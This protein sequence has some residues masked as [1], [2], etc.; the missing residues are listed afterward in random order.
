MAL[1]SV[2]PTDPFLIALAE[3]LVAG[4]FWPAGPPRDDP[5]A[6]ARVTVYLPTRRAARSLADAI[7]EVAPGGATVLP[8]VEALGEVDGDDD[9]PSM[10]ARLALA[11]LVKA[12]AARSS[13]VQ[14]DQ[15]ETIVLAPGV[16]ADAVRLAGELLALL[17]QVAAQELSWDALPG[18]VEEAELAEHW[19][20]ILGFLTIATEG[21]PAIA[22]EHGFTLTADRRRARAAGAIERLA[23]HTDGPVIAAGSTGSLPATRRL[24]AA[25]HQ[26]PM[27]HVVLPGFDRA[28]SAADWDALAA[29]ED[30]PAHAQFGLSQLLAALEARPQDV[31]RLGPRSAGVVQRDLFDGLSSPEHTRAVPD[32]M[33]PFAPE[34][35]PAFQRSGHFA[36]AAYGAKCPRAVPDRMEP[37]APEKPP[38][39]QRSGHFAR[40]ADGAKCPSRTELWRMALRPAQQTHLWPDDRAA[41]ADLGSAC[42]GLTL[43]NA[44]DDRTEAAAIALALRNA[45]DDGATAAL[46][47]PD[48][49]LARRVGHALV[50]LGV[51]AD[52]SAGEALAVTPAGV[53][54]RLLARVAAGA[55]AADWLA[56]IKHPLITFQ[57]ADREG[58]IRAAEHALRGPRM[59]PDAVL[60]Q[61]VTAMADHP[62]ADAMAAALGPFQ[63][64][65]RAA[66]EVATTDLAGAHLAA[67]D[68]AVADR[69]RA[70]C[71]AVRDVLG[72]IARVLPLATNPADWAETFVSLSDGEVLRGPA[73]MAAVQILGPLEARLQSFDRVVLGG[74]NEGVWPAATDTGP[75]MS[76]PMMSAFGLDLPERRTG[77]A[78][79]DIYTLAGHRQVTLTRAARSAGAAMLPSRWWQRLEVFAGDALEGAVA[80]GNTLLA[81]AAALE[82]LEPVQ[83]AARPCPAPP[84]DV[85]PTRFSVTEVA[86]LIRDPYAVYAKRILGLTPLDPLEEITDGGDRGTLFHAVLATFS[87][88]VAPDG[89]DA[90]GVW[91]AASQS[92]LERFAH[93]P[94]AQAVWRQR[95]ELVGP[96]AI[97]EFRAGM[98][99]VTNRLAEVSAEAEVWQEYTLRGRIDRVD[100]L[101]DG[102]VAVIDYKTSAKPPTPNQVATLM[103]PQLP[104]EAGLL[105]LGAL[106]D[107]PRHTPIAELA[108]VQLGQPG[109]PFKRSNVTSDAGGAQQGAEALA[110]LRALLAFYAEPGNGYLARARMQLESVVSDY[111]HLSRADEWRA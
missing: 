12:W 110:R 82:R 67:F 27:G 102:T 55:G 43:V 30:A 53:S 83:P 28:A 45:V 89:S 108:Y 18:L 100:V 90:E 35:P 4:T 22:R 52:D 25:I 31:Q 95:L 49:N 41:F 78:A 37:F 11:T 61:L 65:C 40:A 10:G 85:R 111:D 99:S 57:V 20:L 29:A 93:A 9:A 79:H 73:E 23:E 68:A 38:A 14:E 103:E 91:Q 87:N 76:R 8:R 39:F 88:E 81:Q 48:R 105:G 72:V 5:F 104:L 62:L 54:A 96:A 66:A 24:I 33:E 75:W 101:A 97:A 70:D 15:D 98:G 47:T 56:L 7:L 84:V 34:K 21:W 3:H 42:E 44:E 59:A 51:K 106:A 50:R 36:R 60:G 94:E 19:Q 2:D 63:A 1:Y 86:R 107:V 92:A 58:A 69:D 17:E 109:D 46:V 16:G 71:E 64:V 26:H 77:L 13:A 6:L 74:L 80:R 32:R